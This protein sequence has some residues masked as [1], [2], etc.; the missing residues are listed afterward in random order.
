MYSIGNVYVADTLN[1][2]VR[3]VTVSTGIITTIAGSDTSGSFSGDGSTAILATLYYPQGIAVDS[4]GFD[5][6]FPIYF[7]LFTLSIGNV[8]IADINNQ[9]IRKV[10]VSTGI[11]TT[12]V[13]T[14]SAGNSGDNGPATSA[15]L[16]NPSGVALD[17]SGRTL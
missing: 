1:N 9:R 10:T 17:A 8:Y 6:P 11:I 4:A 5:A 12:I 16:Y 13:G 7:C 15:T 2:R 14:G 3:K